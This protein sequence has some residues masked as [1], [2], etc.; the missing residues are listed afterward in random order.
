M[1][2]EN[3]E[4]KKENGNTS[5][6]E[7]IPRRKDGRSGVNSG[8]EWRWVGWR[9]PRVLGNDFLEIVFWKNSRMRWIPANRRA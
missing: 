9:K 2:E 5:E 3:E 7:A 4:E 1:N 6:S 8:V